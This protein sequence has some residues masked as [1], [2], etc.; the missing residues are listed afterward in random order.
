MSSRCY[1]MARRDT[2][3]QLICCGRRDAFERLAGTGQAGA[4]IV[5]VI[6]ELWP[7][8]TLIRQIHRAA[9]RL[10]ARVIS[11]QTGALPSLNCR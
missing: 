10:M 8:I 9:A 4:D 2:P 6:V 11:P 3:T 7:T 1:G 5:C